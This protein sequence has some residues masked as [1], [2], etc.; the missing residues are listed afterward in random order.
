MKSISIN[1]TKRAAQTKQENIRLRAEGKV[2]CVLYGGK[3]Q[4]HFSTPALSLKGLVYTPNV[5]TVELNIDGTSYKAVMKDIQFHAVSD[6]INHIDFLELD[7]NKKITLEVPVKVSGNAVGVRAGGQLVTKTRRLK[8]S[9]LPKDLP[10]SI[11]ISIN[12][13]NIGDD[14]RVRDIKL[15][16]VEIL[17]SPNSVLTAVK[18]TRAVAAAATDEKAAA[19]TAAKK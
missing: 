10:D 13:L 16:G 3:E 5:Y 9:A 19:A 14:I 4:I 17:N 1:G 8:V 2:P 18:I 12:E 7:D 11:D 15:K 6:R